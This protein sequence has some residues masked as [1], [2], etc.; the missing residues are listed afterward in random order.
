MRSQ[1]IE[2][3]APAA[4]LAVGR[5]AID[6][7]ADAV[8]I[9]G[10]AFG[11]RSAAANSIDDIAE[12]CR[13]AHLFGARVFLTLNTLIHDDEMGEVARI[14]WSAYDAGVD[15]LII[16][17]MRILSVD[18]PPI[19]MHAS[20]QC[21]NA[22]VDQVV[23]LA[24]AG[25]ERV[26]LER[27]LDIDTIAV[28]ARASDVEL[29]MFVHGA[30]CV[31]YSGR[32]NLSEHLTGRSGNRG[33]CAQPCRS[34][35]DLVDSDGRVLVRGEALL[36]PRD[37]NLSDR[38]G[39]IIDAG[40][41]SLKIEGRLKDASYVTNVVSHY[42]RIL[43]GLGAARTSCGRSTAGFEPNPALSFNRGF[44]EWFF[45][46]VAA[47]VSVVKG[48]S[49]EFVGTVT[50]VDGRYFVI[51]NPR[52]ALANGDGITFAGGG[53]RINRVDG[54]RIFPLSMAG[55]EVGMK[56]YRNFSVRFTPR[57]IRAIDV[58]I[59]MTGDGFS[60]SD[61]YGFSSFIAMPVGVDEAR[62]SE[63]ALLTIESCLR[64]SGDTIF[65]VR[66]VNFDLRV[67]P[68]LPISVLNALRRD[69]LA[70]M[71]VNRTVRTEH[72]TTKPVFTTTEERYLMRSRYC[73][74]RERGL[75][76][77]QKPQNFIMPLY[78]ANNRQKIRLTFHCQ[79]CEMSLDY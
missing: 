42:N 55:I 50:A 28:I 9:G 62:D 45:D 7:G 76:L 19:A 58:D 53:V 77:I 63:K 18:M 29:E 75:C 12:L 39:E 43:M 57:A 27:A 79:S 40:V 30:I 35:Y 73:I 11:A 46:G 61:D 78:L 37:M 36:S 21:F 10:P 26:V 51:G 67:V 23:A 66:D 15:A 65:A 13:Y 31:G 41:C 64:K 8:Y 68:F 70:G 47:G 5:A 25:F 33:E 52:F 3:L 44:T 14:A 54:D 1:P 6:A 17:D 2:L 32:C 56:V 22:S 49:G 38:I 16:Q 71:A 4:N 20:T 74:L 34:L 60:V 72:H 48:Q 24:N 69:L 59:T